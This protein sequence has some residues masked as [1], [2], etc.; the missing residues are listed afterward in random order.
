MS[1]FFHFINDMPPPF[2]M[3][4]FIVLICSVGSVISSISKQIR[5]F[6][7]YREELELKRDMLERGM[8]AEEIAAVIRATTVESGSRNA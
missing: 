6:A 4:V 3:I 7:C 8:T 1:N 5:K 2:N